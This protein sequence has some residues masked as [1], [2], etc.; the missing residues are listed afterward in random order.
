MYIHYVTTFHKHIIDYTSEYL[1]FSIYRIRLWAF[2]YQLII[3]FLQFDID[4]KSI[5]IYMPTDWTNETKL[6]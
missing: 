1:R 3:L 5:L 2:I 4:S 6:I